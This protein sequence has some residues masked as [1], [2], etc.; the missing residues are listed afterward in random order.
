MLPFLILALF[1]VIPLRQLGSFVGSSAGAKLEGSQSI[2]NARIP[3]N[4]RESFERD[5]YSRNSREPFERDEYTRNGQRDGRYSRNAREPFERDEYTRNGRDPVE[6]DQYR[7][8][9]SRNGGMGAVEMRLN[10]PGDEENEAPAR[11]RRR[12]ARSSVQRRAPP[13]PP[14]LEELPKRKLSN[15]IN[16]KMLDLGLESSREDIVYSCTAVHGTGRME[17][18][19]KITGLGG[20]VLGYKTLVE[21]WMLPEDVDQTDVPAYFKAK[22]ASEK[23]R[24]AAEHQVAAIALEALKKLSFGVQV[25]G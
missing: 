16:K 12:L 19:V 20:E 5:Q 2:R 11:E 3:R 18:A 8:P 7:S 14:Q 17:V 10:R 6:R 23:A 22:K 15:F 9:A 21:A 25:Q 13:K 4:A 24:K 1:E